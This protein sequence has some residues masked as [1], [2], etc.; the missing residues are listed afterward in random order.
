MKSLIYYMF[1]RP[2]LSYDNAK[3]NEYKTTAREQYATKASRLKNSFSNLKLKNIYHIRKMNVFFLR[4]YL[5]LT[6]EVTQLIFLA[7][8]LFSLLFVRSLYPGN[9]FTSVFRLYFQHNT[10]HSKLWMIYHYLFWICFVWIDDDV[11]FVAVACIAN[12]C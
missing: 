6:I 11:N 1:T 10:T 9:T 7:N 2:N 8:F 3:T 4:I 5:K 12:W